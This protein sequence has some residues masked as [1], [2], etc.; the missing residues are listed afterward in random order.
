MKKIMSFLMAISILI[1]SYAT[2]PALATLNGEKKNVFSEVPALNANNV[3]LP[4]GNTGKKISLMDLSRISIKDFETI[5]G[6][7]LKLI[8]KIGFKLGQ[9][10]L[11]TAIQPDGTIK[12]KAIKKYANKMAA[13]GETGFHLGGFALGFFVG[14]IG[15]LIAYL[16]NDDYKRNRV[17]W[18]WIG[19]G[20]FVVL[21]VILLVALL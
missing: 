16:I 19:W 4:V 18:A 14:L 5:T 10:K 6:K 11:R 13:D 2:S 7:R 12:S 15:V 20:I 8:D 3:M 1:S 17:K 9:K 21:Y